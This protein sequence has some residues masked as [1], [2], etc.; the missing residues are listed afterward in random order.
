[1]ERLADALACHASLRQVVFPQDG[2][3]PEGIV[4]LLAGLAKCHDLEVLD[5]QDNTFT[6]K[7]AKALAEALPS[8]SRL[9]VLNVGDCMLTAKGCLE[10]INALRSSDH[11]DL[12]I[13]NLQYNEMNESGAL[14]LA[15]VVKKYTKLKQLEV[16]GNCFDA[17]GAGADAIRSTL[18]GMNAED[19][20]G[21]LSDMEEEEEEEE[22]E[23]DLTEAMA[24][25]SV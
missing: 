6:L 21:S 16:N 12:E 10:V 24:K 14:A 2:I 17:E 23:E 13:L 8:W 19:V 15:G 7:G 3:R 11:P 9:R 5:L 20:L 4:T 25:V 1:M 22:E 18:E